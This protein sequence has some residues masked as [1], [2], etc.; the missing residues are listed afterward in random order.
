MGEYAKRKGD[1]EEIKIG[2]CETM[3]YIRYE[4]RDKVSALPGNVD[5][6]RAHEY[7]LRFRLPLI[8][9]DG[10]Q[11][12][13]YDGAFPKKIRLSKHVQDPRCP[14][15]A[16]NLKDFKIEGAHPGT[17]TLRHEESGIQVSFPCY[18]GEKIPEN[19]GP[20]YARIR[21]GL[22]GARHAAELAYVKAVKVDGQDRVVPVICCAH[23]G[24]EWATSWEEIWEYI[25]EDYK[26]RLAQYTLAKASP[27]DLQEMAEALGWDD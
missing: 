15:N 10:L 25:P 20:D 3:Y 12:G 1:G 16:S 13:E 24:D 27:A 2:T 22:N 19:M 5:L 9:E 21:F 23:C 4:D 7:G 18:H 6:K 14:T 8:P 26:P 17:I 11:P